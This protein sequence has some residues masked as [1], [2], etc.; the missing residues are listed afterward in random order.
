MSLADRPSLL[1]DEAP[2]GSL[3]AE[4][5]A[6]FVRIQ[7][8]PT[9]SIA[10]RSGN[11]HWIEFNSETQTIMIRFATHTVWLRGRGLDTIHQQLLLHRCREIVVHKEERDT[12]EL[13]V[14]FVTYADV[15]TRP[16][17][18]ALDDP[19]GVA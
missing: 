4:D 18:D 7:K 15:Q 2:H 11:I 12:G 14:P 19:G 10:L 8:T 5:W 17:L 13:G 1:R 3:V 9:E 16:G 6:P